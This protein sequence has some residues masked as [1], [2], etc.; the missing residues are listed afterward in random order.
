MPRK[1][2]TRTF[3]ISQLN[4][5]D[6]TDEGSRIISGYASV[7]NSRTTLWEG[8][9]E[10]VAPGAFTETLKE[11]DVRALFNHDWS[12]V[13]GRTSAKTLTLKEDDHG[14][15]FEVELPNTSYA[16]DLI[17][18]ME[19][20]DINQC[21][22]G[23]YITREEIDWDGDPDATVRTIK[24]VELFEVSVVSLPAYDDTEVAL[25]RSKQEKQDF[26][27]RKKLIQKIKRSLGGK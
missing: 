3:N 11:N 23:F 17:E 19:R 15:N 13:L 5:R 12:K 2:Q 18:S 20:G 1:K 24:E 8:F 6:G 22:F 27:Q 26:V 25:S 21:S 14:L 10:V 7:F 9:D 16:N 4:T